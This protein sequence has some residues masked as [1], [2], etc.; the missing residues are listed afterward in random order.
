MTPLI[1]IPLVVA[2]FLGL[3]LWAGSLDHARIR[4]HYQSRGCEVL[5]LDWNPFGRGWFGSQNERIYLIRYRDREGNTYEATVK[6][7]ILAGVY[8]TD[9]RLLR[10]KEAG[11]QVPTAPEPPSEPG[12]ASEVARLRRKINQLEA[13]LRAERDRRR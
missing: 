13:E 3:R 6:T 8:A 2:A 1:A 10:S 7:S 4:A 9:E 5:T 12:D 11:S